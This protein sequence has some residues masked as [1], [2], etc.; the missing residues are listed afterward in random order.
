MSEAGEFGQSASVPGVTA[1]SRLGR[2]PGRRPSG[3]PPPLPRD[4]RRTGVGWLIG[5]VLAI[6][7]T[8]LIFRNGVSGP[9]IS[10]IVVDDTLVRWMSEIDVPGIH[11]VARIVS[12]AASWWFIEI[13]IWL[14][15]VAMVVFRRW[16]HL[17]IY[18]VVSQL[19]EFAARPAVRH[20]DPTT[21]IRCS[22]P[23]E[24]GRAGHCHRSTCCRSRGC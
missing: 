6:V 12:Y 17:L 13:T 1:P 3:A 19:A 11:G 23:A 18:L 16:R 2:G 21:S 22:S 7:V 4:L 20:G 14:L 8:V 9:A 10:V 24:A 5:A 15:T